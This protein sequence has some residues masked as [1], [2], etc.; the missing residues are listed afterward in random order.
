MLETGPK[1]FGGIAI[2]RF[3]SYAEWSTWDEATLRTDMALT[4]NVL[5]SP[6]SIPRPLAAPFASP[7]QGKFYIFLLPEA[8][9]H[10]CPGRELP[11]SALQRK[12]CLAKEVRPVYGPGGAGGKPFVVA[13]QRGAGWLSRPLQSAVCIPDCG[14]VATWG[15]PG[16]RAVACGV[17]SFPGNRI[18]FSCSMPRRSAYRRRWLAIWKF[19]GL[20]TVT[21]VNHLCALDHGWGCVLGINPYLELNWRSTANAGET[22]STSPRATAR[23]LSFEVDNLPPFLGPRPRCMHIDWAWAREIRGN[24]HTA[25][26]NASSSFVRDTEGKG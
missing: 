14:V 4:S 9:R 23:K 6:C 19:T 10:R 11:W 5:S 24:M 20:R 8:R 21:R 1:N 2:V 3:R 12:C 16:L 17:T 25:D 26:P 15:R 18:H 22:L 7:Y 13:T